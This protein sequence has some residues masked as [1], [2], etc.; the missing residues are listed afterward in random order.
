MIR[1]P[2]AHSNLSDQETAV[3]RLAS[4][5]CTDREIAQKLKVSEKTIDTYW[6]R[7]RQKLDA[8]NRTHAVAIAFKDAYEDKLDPL[9]GCDEMLKECEEGIWIV[10]QRG[11]TVFAN[12]KLADMFGYTLEEMQKMSGWDLLDDEGRVAARKMVEEFPDGRRDSFYFRYKRKDGSDLHVMMSTTPI[13]DDSGR[14]IRS[15]GMLNEIDP[16]TLESELN[17]KG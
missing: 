3:L 8:R 6:S 2:F 14:P 10:D 5:G 16:S 13:T 11:N 9:F 17:G 1:D 15:L 12:Q 7:I 4:E